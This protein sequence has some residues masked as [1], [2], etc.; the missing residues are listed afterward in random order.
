[1]VKRTSLAEGATHLEEFGEG[2]W[3]FER[4]G[5]PSQ[6]RDVDIVSGV[7]GLCIRGRTGVG[8]GG[9]REHSWRRLEKRERAGNFS[10][11][12]CCE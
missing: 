11:L 2:G 4:C 9:G 3:E 1:M 12:K 6:L 8:W 5:N 7:R 10:G